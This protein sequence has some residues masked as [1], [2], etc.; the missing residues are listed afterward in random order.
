[1]PLDPTCFANLNLPPTFTLPLCMDYF[2]LTAPPNTDLWRKPP[3][4]DTAT[5]PIIYT[6]LRRPFNVAEVTISAEW[7]MEWDQGGLVIFAGS[8]PGLSDTG[9]TNGR[10]H[11]RRRPSPSDTTNS[12]RWVKAG[13]EFTGGALS[14]STVVA[15]GSGADLSLMP[16]YPPC[17]PLPA[18]PLSHSSLRIKFERLDSSLWI[19]YQQPGNVF[20]NHYPTSPPGGP[21][22][23]YSVESVAGTWKKLR[24]VTDFFWDIDDKNIH[25][26]VYASR[27][28]SFEAS[29]GGNGTWNGREGGQVANGLVVEFEDLDIL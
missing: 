14:A 21:T 25:I 4:R 19:W 27:P 6:A 29:M 2:T 8:P 17:F 13:L 5:A 18:Y 10:T 12:L 22:D 1:M 24:E 15:N 7:E 11:G 26:G 16:L 23:P 9:V 20:H 3:S 28:T